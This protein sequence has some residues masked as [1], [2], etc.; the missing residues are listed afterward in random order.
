MNSILELKKIS[1][2]KTFT[3]CEIF[4]KISTIMD[5]THLSTPHSTSH[6]SINNTPLYHVY[7]MYTNTIEIEIIYLNQTILFLLLH[8]AISWLDTIHF[9]E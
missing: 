7:K 5:N 6:H 3:I 9:Y 8:Y 2:G 1:I 4:I